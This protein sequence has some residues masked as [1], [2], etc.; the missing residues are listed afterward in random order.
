MIRDPLALWRRA[1]PGDPG[2]EGTPREASTI[3]PDRIST[4]F[5]RPPTTSPLP[6]A[7]RR[8]KLGLRARF[9]LGTSL[10]VVVVLLAV[11]IVMERRQRQFMYEQYQA[12]GLAI[13]RLTASLAMPFLLNDDRAGL[14]R[15]ASQIDNE[16]GLAYVVFV[17]PDRGVVASSGPTDSLPPVESTSPSYRSLDLE[18][19]DGQESQPV[20]DVA[21]SIPASGI[22]GLGVHGTVRVGL[23]LVDMLREVRRTRLRLLGIG[24]IALALTIAGSYFLAR[25]VS[26]PIQ[27]LVGMTIRAAKGDLLG[28][29]KIQS[30]DEIGELARNFNH[31][32]EQIQ[33]NQKKIED[34]N[35]N[36]ERKV[37]IRTQELESSNHA[38]K[39][40]FQELKQA[41][42]QMIQSEKMASL[43]QLVAGIAHEINTPTSAINAAADNLR[44]NMSTLGAV[45]QSIASL[46]QADPLQLS[47]HRLL[48][49]A[50]D[51]SATMKRTTLAN[52]RERSQALEDL[53][54]ANGLGD[55]R[56]LAFSLA[57]L[58]LHQEMTQLLQALPRESVDVVIPFVRDVTTMTTAIA[59]VQYSV[60]T[61]MRM[62]KALRSYSHQDQA[63]MVEVNLHDGIE[64]TL[65]ILHSHL[66][67]GVE[68]ERRYGNIPLVLGNPSELNQVWTNIIINAIQAMKGNGTIVIE[69]QHAGGWVSVR[70]TDNGPG[71]PPKILGRIFDPFFTT[72]DQGEGTGL[73][74]SICQQIVRRSAG[75]INVAS[76]MGETCFEV[77][78]P[79]PEQQAPPP[80]TEEPARAPRERDTDPARRR[81]V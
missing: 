3:D 30:D 6:G 63:E 79:S 18:D 62:V 14:E 24:E 37:R 71:I 69:T 45:L 64:T 50:T 20:L 56:E 44:Y 42:S 17:G 54:I 55:Q 8:L 36:L 65:I 23:S 73:G 61:I 81:P 80:A 52:L 38:L 13:A 77:T 46:P 31:M 66:K 41:E 29:I 4:P 43:G 11:A 28:R 76:R 48:S 59:D 58:E 33:L 7:S 19:P 34:L 32:V 12:R 49:K 67:Y 15:L 26:L 51:S 57:R 1:T 27:N 53:F 9:M 72:K 16:A 70:I 47:L 78:F 10:L 68:V 75:K 2:E 21:F 25:R 22:G 60:A 35:R 40:A 74:L 39:R 5:E